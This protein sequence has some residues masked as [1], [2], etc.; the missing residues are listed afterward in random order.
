MNADGTGQ[1]RI[2][3]NPGSDRYPAWSPGDNRF[4]FAS[5]RTENFE[6]YTMDA[7]GGGVTQFTN[8]P[9]IDADPVW[10]PDGAKI[11]FASPRDGNAEIYRMN[12]DGSNVVRL[13]NDPA[14]DAGPDWW[15]PEGKASGYSGSNREPPGPKPGAL[16]IELYPG[17]GNFIKLPRNQIYANA[18]SEP[19]AL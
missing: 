13:T 19:G 12:A 7:D 3:N 1:T 16:P 6:V 15:P 10:S 2:T 4:V 9:A 17:S 18:T 14:L 11:S 8:N 5:D